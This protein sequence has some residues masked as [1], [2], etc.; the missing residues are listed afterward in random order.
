MNKTIFAFSRGCSSLFLPPSQPSGRRRWHTPIKSPATVFSRLFRSTAA[1][2]PLFF[3]STPSAAGIGILFATAIV[4]AMPLCSPLLATDDHN[5]IGVSGVFEGVTTTG[6]A[7]NVLNHNASRQI[8]DIVVPGAVGKYGLKMTRYYNSRSTKYPGPALMGPGW[9]HEYFWANYGDKVDYPNGNA[10]DSH[11][12]GDWTPLGGPLGVSDWLTTSSGYP[13][14]RLADGGTVVFENPSWGVATKIIDPY[15]QVTT[16]TLDSN[17]LMTQVTEPG[18]RYLQFIYSVVNGATMLHEVD[19]YDGRGNQ[20]DSVI[21]NYTSISPG[22]QYGPSLNCLTSVNYSDGQIA[23]YTYTTDN[24]PDHPTQCPCTTKIL[25][26]VK[27]CKDVR[28]KGAMRNICYDY[29]DQGPHGAITAERYSL[30]GST[31]GVQVSKIDPPAPSPLLSPITFSPSYTETRADGPTRTFNYTAL[32]ITRPPPEEECPSING[33]PPQQFLQ[34][35]TD[36]QVPVHTTYLTYDGNWYVNSVKDANLHT[37]NYLRGPPPNAFPGPKGI[38]QITKITH[39]DTTHIDY[40]YQDEPGVIGGHYLQQITD[41]RGNMTYYTRDSNHRITRIDYKNAALTVLAY[42]TFSYNGFGQVL[43]H[44][45]KNG[46]NE[47]FVYDTRGLVTNKYNPKF[48]SVPSGTDPHTQYAYYTGVDGKPGWIDRVKKMTLPANV[49]GLVAS[50]T[51]EYDTDSSGNGVP[52]RGQVTKITHTDGTYQSFDYDLYGNKLWEENELRQRTTY[53]YDEYSRL[54]T[55]KNPLLKTMNYT[56]IPTNG[57]G[58]SYEHTTGNPD[59]VTTP[60]GIVTSN[61]YDPNFRK[62]STTAAEGTALAATTV[63]GYDNVGN[64]TLITDPLTHKTYNTYDTRN[65]KVT[66]TDAY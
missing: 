3:N 52:G 42:E 62:T 56:Y 39:P 60:T 46:A 37:T 38:G 5:P 17:G 44:R 64:L 50:E 36:F 6:G 40:T 8:D 63:F 4:F 11:C 33:Q 23:S 29:Q 26:L 57:G 47:S 15:G 32:T 35:Y 24:Q 48:D 1:A 20:I 12:T 21:Y 34:S 7:Y 19:A 30:N 31:N 65:R 43:T 10:W 54:L 55:A 58:L 51:Y 61:I 22:G 16:I 13:A 53:T 27:T 2:N 18:G 14:F 25:P 9:G 45:L 28:Y 59:T 66:T 41:E 49:S